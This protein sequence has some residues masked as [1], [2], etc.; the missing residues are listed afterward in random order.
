MRLGFGE[1]A[2]C[3]E[4]GGEVRVNSEKNLVA[5]RTIPQEP[6]MIMSLGAARFLQSYLN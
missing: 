4:H 3:G 1:G 5:G 2:K 6:I